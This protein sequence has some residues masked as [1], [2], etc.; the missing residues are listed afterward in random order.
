MNINFNTLFDVD[1]F[2]EYYKDGISRDFEIA[3]TDECKNLLRDYRLL[4]RNTIRG[5]GVSCEADVNENSIIPI[6]SQIKLSF[7]LVCKNP[8]LLNY[9]NLPFDKIKNIVYYFSNHDLSPGKTTL[10]KNNEYLS[11]EDR[12]E[13]QSDFLSWQEI[14]DEKEIGVIINDI[15]SK[16]II[17][18][19]FKVFNK[20]A[21]VSLDLNPFSLGKLSM[22][23]N[24]AK[25]VEF[26][27]GKNLFGK[28]VFGIVEI[29][30]DK[31]SIIPA[32]YQIK[33]QRRKTFW[34][35]NVILKT[36]TSI[37]AENL[38]VDIL[39][40][41][42]DKLKYTFPDKLIKNKD[43]NARIVFER[44]D[45]IAAIGNPDCI[46]FISFSELPLKEETIAGIRLVEIKQGGRGGT[47]YGIVLIENLSNPPVNS[48]K[49]DQ[50]Q[51]KI[52]SEI[53]IYI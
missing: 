28:K 37:L 44:E 19:S 50:D 6:D 30:I 22:S 49:Y 16:K 51:L 46:P 36:N 48:I 2:H 32:S 20:A 40:S 1:I 52:Y 35:Y 13:L 10:H 7:V 17:D 33:I 12:I 39:K 27:S 14:T 3:P 18:K 21:D 41:E 34:K 45:K 8:F 42:T 53:N 25:E 31:S 47:D 23:I 11:K 26:Y 29:F 5:F 9:S 24:G 4:F 38:S 43:T 15:S